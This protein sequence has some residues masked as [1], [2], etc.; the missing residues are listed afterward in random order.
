M[1][2]G[3]AGSLKCER[4]ARWRASEDSFG[5]LIN[6]AC[7]RLSTRSTRH[8]DAA[9][10]TASPFTI[11]KCIASLWRC[12]FTKKAPIAITV[13]EGFFPSSLM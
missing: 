9:Y 2:S 8:S 7:H 5:I 4:P 11:P 13:G 1:G 10:L 6:Y 12:T 3:V